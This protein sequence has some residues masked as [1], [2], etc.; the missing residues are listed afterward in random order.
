MRFFKENYTECG[1]FLINDLHKAF[2]EW[3][4]HYKEKKIE[5]VVVG[6]FEYTQM[7]DW[8]Y[9]VTYTKNCPKENMVSSHEFNKALQNHRFILNGLDIEIQLSTRKNFLELL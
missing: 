3:N 9:E 6:R 7:L 1:L 8:A 5:K 4:R 2:V